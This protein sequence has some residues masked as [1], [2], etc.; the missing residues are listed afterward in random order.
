MKVIR[1]LYSTSN[2]G[3]KSSQKSVKLK[4]N[5]VGREISRSEILSNEQVSGSIYLSFIYLHLS[6]LLL[7][8][9]FYS[10]ASRFYDNYMILMTL[11]F[12][13]YVMFFM[14]LILII[15]ILYLCGIKRFLIDNVKR[16]R[17]GYVCLWGGISS[18]A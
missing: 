8:C 12:N 5:H 11:I 3:V 4:W 7:C 9:F 18:G 6:A 2:I 15:S 1:W 17:V 16:T 13:A 14:I 10:C